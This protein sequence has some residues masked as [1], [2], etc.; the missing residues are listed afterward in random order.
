MTSK[1]QIHLREIRRM[2]RECAPGHV[3][4]EKDHRIKVTHGDK[5]YWKLPTGHGSGG[6][7]QRPHVKKLAQVLEILD[8]AKREI[9]SL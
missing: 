8:C 6:Q 7:I 3:W 1:G 4:D 9:P 5:I 2:L